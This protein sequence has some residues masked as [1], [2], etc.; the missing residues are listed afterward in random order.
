[1]YSQQIFDLR[2]RVDF[3]PCKKSYLS[4]GSFSWAF[5]R[6]VDVKAWYRLIYPSPQNPRRLRTLNYQHDK[7]FD[8]LSSTEEQIYPRAEIFLIERERDFIVIL[9]EYYS[10]TASIVLNIQ[11]LGI[12]TCFMNIRLTVYEPYFVCCK[13]F[14]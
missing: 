4:D 9:S 3:E 10:I 7:R 1:M 13:I 2:L 14:L 8:I 5:R 12:W 6:T 11:K